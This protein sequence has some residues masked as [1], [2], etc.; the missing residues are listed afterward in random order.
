MHTGQRQ[1][2]QGR[3][4]GD[5]LHAAHEVRGENGA[6]LNL[7][8]RDLSPQNLM[9]G[10]DGRVK[11]LDFGVAKARSQLSVTLPGLVKGK[12]SLLGI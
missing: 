10:F 6:L 8:H 7:V 9:V 4:D 5:G 1:G 12:P 3:L 11:L 2:I